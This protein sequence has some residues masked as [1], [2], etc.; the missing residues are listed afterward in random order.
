MKKICF[1]STVRIIP[2][3]IASSS[4]DLNSSLRNH[5]PR[6]TLKS[7]GPVT[8]FIPKL[9]LTVTG[10]YRTYTGFSIN[11]CGTYNDWFKTNKCY[12]IFA[13]SVYA[14]FLLF[15][16]YVLL[17]KHIVSKNIQYSALSRLFAFLCYYSTAFF[18]IFQI[19]AFY[20][21]A[22]FVF[23]VISDCLLF[24]NNQ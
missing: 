15:V 10:S 13:I 12:L 22:H 23:I 8:S 4:P 16:Q 17:P 20:L 7:H 5:L 1:L 3:P 18:T 24:F 2:I 9:P 14:D 6:P 21:T 11:P 19:S